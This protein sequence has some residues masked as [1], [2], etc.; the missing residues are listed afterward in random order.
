MALN[1]AI[2]QGQA[3]I[4]EGLKTGQMRSDNPSRHTGPKDREHALDGVVP[5]RAELLKSKD[6]SPMDW[7]LSSKATLILLSA[8]VLLVLG[9]WLTAS[10]LQ[11]S[12]PAAEP[13]QPVAKSPINENPVPKQNIPLREQVQSDTKSEALTTVPA[14]PQGDNVICIQSMPFDRRNELV[15]VAEFFKRNG[16]DTEIIADH[17]SGNAV[18][19]TKIGFE[20]NPAKQGTNG[21]ELF[22]RIKQLG[23]VYVQETKDTKFGVKPFQDAYGYKR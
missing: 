18:L 20:Q 11:R 6:K 19:A 17:V 7:F 1:E 4:A 10:F 2:R 15:P 8:F 21:Y 5:G 3:K 22:Q 14:T 16:I 12:V 9:L 23:P 13:D